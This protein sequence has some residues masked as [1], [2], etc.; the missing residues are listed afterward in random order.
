M[1]PVDIRVIAIK[2]YTAAQAMAKRNNISELK[3]QL[4]LTYYPSF[5]WIVVNTALHI[6]QME[7]EEL[8]KETQE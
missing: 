5:W 1:N 8:E 7:L 6:K 4:Y 3:L 2:P